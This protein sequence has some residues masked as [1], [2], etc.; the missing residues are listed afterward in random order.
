LSRV[1]RLPTTAIILCGGRGRRLG[2]VDKALVDLGGKPLVQHVI[3]RLEPQVDAIVLSGPRDPVQYRQFG[4]PVI[5]DEDSDQGPLAGIISAFAA[6]ETIWLLTTPVDTPFLPPD[7]VTSLASPCWFG[8]AAVVRAGGHRQNLAML[9]NLARFEALA[10][11][12]E[13]GGRAVHRWLTANDV[14]EVEFPAAAFFNVNTPDDLQ[15]ARER[16]AS[17]N[18]DRAN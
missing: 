17:Y 6:V 10:D 3:E 14:E 5:G 18:S 4:Y 1:E 15:R 13:S 2:G 11:Y 16:V 12:Y 7:L 9:L 8:G